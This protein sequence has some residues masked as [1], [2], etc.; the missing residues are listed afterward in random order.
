[1]CLRTGLALLFL[2]T[3]RSGGI[4]N[5]TDCRQAP[6]GNAVLWRPWIW[7]SILATGP[8]RSG[9]GA[10]ILDLEQQWLFAVLLHGANNTGGSVLGWCCEHRMHWLILAFIVHR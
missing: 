8:H 5:L 10:F 4:V 6:L 7:V 2:G 3:P 1:M 9:A